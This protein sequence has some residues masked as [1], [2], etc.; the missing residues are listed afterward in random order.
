MVFLTQDLDNAERCL[1]FNAE[2]I[3][4]QGHHGLS[5]TVIMIGGIAETVIVWE[6]RNPAK[7]M[8]CKKSKCKKDKSHI[9]VENQRTQVWTIGHGDLV[10]VY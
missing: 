10:S 7:R 9:K 8:K 6:K 1:T 4:G 3:K 2:R 5:T